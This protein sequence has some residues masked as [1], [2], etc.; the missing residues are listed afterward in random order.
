MSFENEIALR[1]LKDRLSLPFSG[2]S[3][4]TDWRQVLFTPVSIPSDSVDWIRF[5]SQGK[6]F[7][8]ARLIKTEMNS[9]YRFPESDSIQLNER[10][11]SIFPAHKLRQEESDLRS[12]RKE[13][14]E[15]WRVESDHIVPNKYVDIVLCFISP[16]LFS[17]RWQ[18]SSL[19]DGKWFSSSKERNRSRTS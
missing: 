7:D 11:I 13:L 12:A 10:A 4:I 6:P 17:P 2:L 1:T 19:I 18:C 3:D 14:L 5:V 8:C 9:L 15:T 16:F